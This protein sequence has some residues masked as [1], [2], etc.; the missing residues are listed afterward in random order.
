MGRLL[1]IDDDA[2]VRTGMRRY[3][4]AHGYEVVEAETSGAAEHEFRVRPPDLAILDYGLPDVTGLELLPVL[5]QIDDRVPIV[6]LTGHGS[7]DLAVQAVK[8]G[9]EDFLEKPVQLPTLLE[10]VRRALESDRAR[11]PVDLTLD[12]AE[13][14]HVELVLRHESGSVEAAAAR[15]GISRSALYVRLKR[16]RG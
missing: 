11:H 14:K 13:R 6:M 10:I 2:G 5:Q 1:V 7:I 15:L 16:Y 12:E 4:E 3:F 9:A 8:Q